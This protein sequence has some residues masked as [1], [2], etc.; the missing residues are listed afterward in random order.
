MSEESTTVSN[1]ELTRGVFASATRADFDAMMS[2]IG[3]DSVWD[4]AP[5]GLGTHTGLAA[6]RH[7]LELWIGSF[8]EYQVV[9][10]EMLDL[11]NGVIFTLVAQHAHSGGSRGHVQLRSAS[12]FVWAD[13]VVERVTHYRNIDEG[14]AAAERLAQGRADG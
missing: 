14:R 1:I 7:F 3:P 6:I 13:S 10:E 9:A 8:D 12:V 4:V 2:F 5:W 11:G